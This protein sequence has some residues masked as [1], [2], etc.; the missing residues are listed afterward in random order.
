MPDTEAAWKP[1]VQHDSEVPALCGQEGLGLLYTGKNKTDPQDLL[2]YREEE[3]Q[4]EFG[5]PRLQAEQGQILRE[6][7]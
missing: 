5:M 6:I 7:K 4:A 1:D 2:A 3:D